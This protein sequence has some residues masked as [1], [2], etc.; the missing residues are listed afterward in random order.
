MS[1]APQEEAKRCNN[2]SAPEKTGGECTETRRQRL[3]E[4]IARLLARHW[5]RE[6]AAADEDDRPGTDDDGDEQRP[7]TTD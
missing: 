1:S 5:I 7:A 6:Q 3:A 2:G 4:R